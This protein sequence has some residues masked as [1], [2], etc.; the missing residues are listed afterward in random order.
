MGAGVA[1]GIAMGFAAKYLYKI[2]LDYDGLYFVFK[3]AVVLLCYGL[4]D[5]IQA[6]GMMACYVCGIT[7]SHIHFHYQ[8]RYINHLQKR[9][10]RVEP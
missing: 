5:Y 10:R 7:M 8:K 2:K 9:L 6:N 4:T 3:I 1:M